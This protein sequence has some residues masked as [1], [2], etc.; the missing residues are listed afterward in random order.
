MWCIAFILIS[1]SAMTLLAASIASTHT[2][3]KFLLRRYELGQRSAVEEL[4]IV[5]GSGAEGIDKTSCAHATPPMPPDLRA[6]SEGRAPSPTGFPAPT[7]AGYSP[8]RSE[9]RPP[10]RSELVPS[11]DRAA[12]KAL[13][14]QLA[15][16]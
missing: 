4:K 13:I 15:S 3:R 12:A 5:L 6:L 16:V 9:E 10:R 14:S 8:P 7:A 1:T 11:V 2:Q